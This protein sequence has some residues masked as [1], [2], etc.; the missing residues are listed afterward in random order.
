VTG[1]GGGIGREHALLLAAEGAA[2][3]VND[4]GGDSH[5]TPGTVA[6]AE[7]VVDE[8]RAPPDR[9][10]RRVNRAD[11]HR[12]TVLVDGTGLAA[13]RA[14]RRN[15]ADAGPDRSM[16]EAAQGRVGAR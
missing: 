9:R 6:R 10:A 14:A 3:V 2:V 4:Y 15:L 7:A 12:V 8:I 11:R 13:V 5:G 1:A 16:G